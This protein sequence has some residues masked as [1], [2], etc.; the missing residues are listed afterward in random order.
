[1]LT[2]LQ[3]ACIDLRAS[4]DSFFDEQGLFDVSVQSTLG[5]THEDV[6]ALDA[7][8]DVSKA[9]G[10]YGETA[11]IQV[12]GKRQSIDVK[13]LSEQGIN[14]P[15][16]T[17]G[18]LPGR[19]GEVA[20]TEKYMKDSGKSIGDTVEF[21]ADIANDEKTADALSGGQSEAVFKGGAYTI[22]GVV[23]DPANI[24]NPDGPAAFRSATS[25][26]YTFFV[27]RDA[28]QS[29]VF[30][31]VYMWLSG[32]DNLVCYSSGYEK[33]VHSA[34][35]EIEGIK[36]ER[37]H[38][39]TES[40]K[41]EAQAKVSDAARA[42]QEGFAEA[43]AQLAAAQ[44]TLDE[45]RN[46]LASGR[47]ELQAQQ[48]SADAQLAAAQQRIDDG[49]AQLSVGEQQLEESSVQVTQGRV[50]LEQGKAQLQSIE[51]QTNQQFA[52]Q[53]AQLIAAGAPPEQIAALDTQWEA[54]KQAFAQQWDALLAQEEQLAAA[55]Q[56]VDAGRVE[57][58]NQRS[59]LDEGASQLASQRQSAQ[60]QIAA[61]ESKLAEGFAQLESGQ[62]TLDT[63]REDYLQKRTETEAKIADAQAEVDA[64]EGATWYIQDRTSLGSYAS[65][66]SDA[67]SIEAVGTAFPIVFFIV[68]ILISL[69]TVTRMVEEDRGLIG[70]Y[71]ALGLR[72]REI[73]SKYVIYAL[74]ACL[75]GGLVGDILGFVGLPEFVFS[76]FA[77]MY[78]LPDYVLQFDWFYGLGGI[79]LFTVGIVGSTVFA[80]WAELRQTPA[81]L[82]RP[83][84]PRK[85]SRI[86]LEH[87]GPVWRRLSFLSKVT[88]RNLFR[89]KKRLFMTVAGIMGCTALLVCG[90]A[91]NDSVSYLGPQQYNHVYAYDLMAVTTPDDY[92]KVIADLQSGGEVADL[93]EARVDSVSVKYNGG[94]E[95][96]QLVVVPKEGS[97]NGYIT[98]EDAS[99]TLVELGSNDM[100]V[101]RNAAQVLGFSEGD[102]VVL[103][104]TSLAE[105][106]VA[107][108]R[109][110]EN[111]LGNAVYLGQDA[112]ERLFGTY[113]PN[114][115]FAHLS[116]DDQVS[117]A[118]NLARRDGVLSSVSTQELRDNFKS[119]F[120]LVSSVVYL[121]TAMAAALAFVVLF[122]LS[123]TNIS[124]RER[125]LATIKVL[126]F[127]KGEVHHYVNRETLIL[128]GFGILLGLPLGHVLGNLLT[129]ALNMPSIYF[130]VHIEWTSYLL[131]AALSFVFALIVNLITNRS[132]D[133]INMV[134][135]LKSVE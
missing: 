16:V 65:I 106:G 50:Q 3:V 100:F 55:Q 13:A 104:D 132:L 119:S 7:L 68:A 79:A 33:L 95:S 125:E 88:A 38:L 126:G 19:A 6:E 43:E 51:A 34:R 89:Y 114:G 44:A 46:T 103:K 22:T 128:T 110:V 67:S 26:D 86:F 115:L 9:E 71:K 121:I 59:T 14:E 5:L 84:S 69:T 124:E 111:Y 130:A 116:T 35:D 105:H 70:T 30:T 53:R 85:G 75:I 25:S 108:D 77:T 4:A 98:L 82:M 31:A 24:A 12:D 63:Q 64:I 94:E 27:S 8:D 11:Y 97:L 58:A 134:E 101:T 48:A 15:Y 66:D 18:D 133:R 78:V 109:I 83:K 21:D 93:Q 123:T 112:Y 91:I 1:M 107:V 61:G 135:A 81:A 57:L 102:E 36:A 39:R 74:S 113:K 10:S 49:Y 52:D 32:A 99:G 29:D 17:Q 96:M 45:S 2:G 47:A 131:A 41:A 87:I 54:A 28:V 117:F 118:D 73:L 76:I 80:C 60:Q 23:V 92:D 62:A 37:Q 72:N 40:V 129:V 56:Q 20:V 127:R 90:F 122:T 120:S 42:A